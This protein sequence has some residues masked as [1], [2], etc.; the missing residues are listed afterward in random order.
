MAADPPL[1]HTRSARLTLVSLLLIPLLSLAA[2]WVFTASVALGNVIRY[3]HYNTVETTIFPSVTSLE[4]ALPVERAITL[5][6]LGGDRRSTGP[7]RRSAARSWRSAG[8][9]T[10]RR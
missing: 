6:W 2:L 9:W 4:K 5:I 8:C 3:Q 7:P 10:P 1:P